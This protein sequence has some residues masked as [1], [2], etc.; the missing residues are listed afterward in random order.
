MTHRFYI[1][2]FRTAFLVAGAVA[3]FAAAGCSKQEAD[4]KGSAS[5]M[6]IEPEVEGTKAEL[7]NDA[8]GLRD[9]K[10]G[11][12]GVS[13][14][15]GTTLVKDKVAMTY[16]GG[17]WQH[18]SD[19]ETWKW[20]GNTYYAFMAWS[21]A[22]L[23]GTIGGSISHT[24]FG[25]F[26]YSGIADQKDIMLGYYGGKGVPGANNTCAAPIKFSHALASVQ[27]KAGTMTALSNINSVKVSGV[28]PTGTCTVTTATPPSYAWKNITGTA[29]E[30]SQ[31]GL[32]VSPA[33]GNPAIGTPFLLL[34]Q[35]LSASNSLTVTLNVTPTT[36][37]AKDITLTVDSGTLTPG[38]TTVYSINYDGQTAGFTVSIEGWG[39]ATD[40]GTVTVDE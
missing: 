27:F 33:S 12:F 30:I 8:D 31:T 11:G 36:G 10:Q 37:S 3:M 19:S 29:M 39:T 40:G 4:K 15:S 5:L 35:T 38:K 6:T 9:E 32:T 17:G 28:K 18:K 16:E 26:T 23:T 1:S 21:P 13:I 2:Q 14:Y 34:P 22:D 7:V 25:E 20:P 24:G